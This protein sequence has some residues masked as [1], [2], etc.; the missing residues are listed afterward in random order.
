MKTTLELLKDAKDI[1]TNYKFKFEDGD[2]MPTL[3]QEKY[4]EIPL[5]NGYTEALLQEHNIGSKEYEISVNEP[6][7]KMNYKLAKTAR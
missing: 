6:V 3:K 2:K 7:K 4:I 5:S 1:Q